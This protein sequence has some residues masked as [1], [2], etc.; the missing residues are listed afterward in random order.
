MNKIINC[1]SVMICS[2]LLFSCKKNADI[3][4]QSLSK[5]GEEFY[6]GEKVPVWAATSGDKDGIRY[7]WSATGGTFDGFRTQDLF[8]N[9]WIAPAQA[10]EYTVT[11]KAKNGGSNSSRSTVMKVTR[12]FFDEFQSAYTFNGNGWST[13]NTATPVLKND[14][15]P[16][17]STAELTASSSSTPNIRRTLNLAPL[18]LPFSIRTKLGWKNFYRDGSNMYF[19]LFF[20]QPAKTEIPYIREIRWEIWPTANPAATDN[21]QIRYELFTP[22]TNTS[23][24]SGDANTLP[25]PLPLIS[26]VKGKNVQLTLAK[27]E[28]KSFT[29]SVDKNELFSTY[30]N[31][32]LWF[33]SDGLKKWLEY[34]RA[35]YPGYEEP[36][37][38]EYRI[39]F[40]SKSGST[41]TTISLKSVYI[42]NDGTPLNNP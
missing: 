39:T 28:L 18:K 8:E 40:P 11:A 29:F 14:V 31:G 33:E 19:S 36:L 16:A 26:P 4:I 41:G 7:E 1:F 37:A 42:N 21:Y 12:Y 24:W 13:S 32:V 2:F 38:K 5:S 23:V 6:F 15:D 22:A 34:A 20:V 27:D 35:T 30:V 9:L 10:G 3:Q 17:K 25:A